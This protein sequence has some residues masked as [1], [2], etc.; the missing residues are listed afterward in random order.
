MFEPNTP[1][2]SPY[3]SVSGV[4]HDIEGVPEILPEFELGLAD[5]EGFSLRPI[6]RRQSS[7]RRRATPSPRRPNPIALTVLEPLGPNRPRLNVRGVD[8]FDGLPI[9]DSRH[10]L[11]A[12]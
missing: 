2:R 9:L 1:I 4:K 10:L 8:M 12:L 5:L 3:P 6:S 11:H 7:P